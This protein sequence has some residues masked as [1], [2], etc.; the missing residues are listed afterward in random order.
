MAQ[1]DDENVVILE[2]IDE[3]QS[4]ETSS[5]DEPDNSQEEGLVSLDE[6]EPVVQEEP[7][8]EAQ[9]ET[10]KSKKKLFIIGGAAGALVTIIAV[11]LFFVFRGE[12]KPPIDEK[13]IVKDIEEHY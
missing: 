6:L 4:P 9:E 13:Q 10:K 11:V 7:P 1:N 3:E 12:K 2:D 5:L 8:Q